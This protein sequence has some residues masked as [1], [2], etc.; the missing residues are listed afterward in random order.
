MVV[1]YHLGMAYIKPLQKN[2]MA[3]LCVSFI[4]LAL[5]ASV[6]FGQAS[7]GDGRDGDAV[8]P[9]DLFN[10]PPK[11]H[12]L[13]GN[14]PAPD[15]PTDPD[16]L[17]QAEPK[18]ETPADQAIDEELR[19]RKDLGPDPRRAALP[20]LSDDRDERL[21][22]LFE[23]LTTT[24]NPFLAKK[25]EEEILKTWSRS[26][27]ETINLLMQ[28]ATGAIEKREFG[29]ALDF[30]DNIIR[31]EPNFAEGWNKRATVYYMQQELGRSIADVEQTL[32]LEP[33]HFGALAGLGLMLRDM[34]QSEEALFALRQALEANPTLD[35]VREAITKLE[36][37]AE[38][39][40]I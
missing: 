20:Q 30:L 34:G 17:G 22:T 3:A 31:L 16:V 1:Y 5:S 10:K 13:P 4:A 37:T 21:A 32:A 23:T 33:R 19:E 12:E 35:R 14:E 38:G 40:D 29:K 8:H 11:P 9:F 36:K 27:S 28:W 2:R 39:R 15:G 6:A 18:A 24:K 25:A 26:D 7:G